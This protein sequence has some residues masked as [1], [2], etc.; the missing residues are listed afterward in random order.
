M[1]CRVKPGNDD[2]P[3]TPS[4]EGSIDLARDAGMSTG[5]VWQGGVYSRLRA[6]DFVAASLIKN[7]V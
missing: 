6:R 3:L 1:D 7:N 4:G 2:L 5:R